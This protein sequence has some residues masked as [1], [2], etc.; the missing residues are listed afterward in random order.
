MF[1]DSRERCQLE[2]LGQFLITGA[3][4]VLFDEVGDKIEHLFLTFSQSH[5]SIVGRTK[6]EVKGDGV[7]KGGSV[8]DSDLVS[9]ASQSPVFQ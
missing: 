5:G 3:V 8:P 6:G 9:N 1:V 4:A 7:I 2:T